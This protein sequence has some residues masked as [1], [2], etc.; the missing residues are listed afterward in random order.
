MSAQ[1]GEVVAA[2][3]GRARNLLPYTSAEDD[4]LVKL[5]AEEWSIPSIA[6]RLGRSQPSVEARLVHLGFDVGTSRG[7]QLD[8]LTDLPTAEDRGA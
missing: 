6:V 8:L 7:E 5:F 1:V 4:Y 3:S 2:Q